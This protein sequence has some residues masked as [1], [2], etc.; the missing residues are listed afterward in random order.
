MLQYL[1]IFHTHFLRVFLMNK[2]VKTQFHLSFTFVLL[3]STILAVT[4]IA[5]NAET[6]LWSDEFN[7]GTD[8]DTDTWTA[9]LGNWGWGNN[10]L[11]N[12]TNDPANLRVENGNLVIA[13]QRNGSGASASFTSARIKSIEKLTVKYGT[14]EARIKVPDLGNGLWPAFWTLGNN[15]SQVGWPFCGELDIME[16]GH[17]SAIDDNVVNSRTGSAAHWDNSGDYASY[18][19]FQDAAIDL[20]DDFHVFRMEWTPESVT[21]YVDGNW[22]WSMDITSTAEFSE[23]HTPHFILF[24]LAVGGTFTGILNPSDISASFSAEYLIDYV[25]IYD[26]GHT[27]LGGSSLDGGTGSPAGSR[28]ID[29][30]DTTIDTTSDLEWLD[31][32]LTQGISAQDVLAG[33]GGYI[34]DGWT[35]ATV[36]EVCTLFEALG[37]DTTNC[38]AGATSVQMDPNNA[39]ILVNLLGS[40]AATGNGAYGMFD[41]ITGFPDNFGLACI[42]DTATTCTGGG[43]SSW[44]TKNGWASGYQTVG[45]FLVRYISE[46]PQDTDGDGVPNTSDQCPDTSV[47]TVVDTYGCVAS[48]MTLIDNGDTTID[49]SSGLEWLDLTLTQGVSAQDLLAGFGGYITDGWAFATVEEVC[50]L[51]AA[52]GDETTN[53]IVGAAGMQMDPSNAKILVNLLGNTLATGRGAY[54]MFDNIVG[55]PDNF[56]LACINDTATSCTG[57]SDSSWL[58]LNEWASGYQTV[59]SFLVRYVTDP[60]IDT[61]G[62]GVPDT[63]DQCPDTSVGVTIDTDGCPLTTSLHIE[64]EDYA[65]YSDSDLGSNGTAGNSGDDVDIESTTDVSGGRNV[66]WTAAGEWLEYQVNLSAGIYSVKS[67]VAS[68]VSTGAYE[69]MLE[70]VVFAS[71]TVA[72]TGGWQVWETHDLGHITIDTSRQYTLRVNVTGN[73]FNLNWFELTQVVEVDTDADGVPDA[74]DQCHGT[75]SGS[76]VDIQG[77]E[78]VAVNNEVSFANERLV[79]GVDSLFPSFTLYT[80]DNDLSAP[81]SSVCNQGCATTWPPVLVEDVEASGVN[82]LSTIE[83]DDGT[84]QATYNGRP[85]YF[86]AGDNAIND[87]RGDGAGGVWSLVTDD[88]LG[89]VSALYDESTVLEPD[90]QFETDVALVTRF[91]DRPRTRHAREDEFQSYDHYIKFY[92]ENRSSNIEIVDYVAKGGDTIE[93]NVRTLFPLSPIEAENRW[94]YQGIY[95]VAQYASNGTMNYQGFDGIYYHYQKTSNNNTRLGRPIQPGDRMEFEI[96]QFSAAGIPRGQANYYGTTFLYIV[97]EGIVPWY[98]EAAGSHFREDSQKIPEEYW[99]GGNTTIHHQYTDEPNDNFLQMATNLG[100]DNGQTFLLGRRV[101]HSSVIDGTHDEDPAN[102]VLTASV[103]LAGTHY[104][105]QRCTACHERN[106]GAPVATNGVSLDRWVFKVGDINGDPDPFLGSVLQSKGSAGEGDVSIAS[107]TEHADGLRS[108]NYQFSE[109]APATFSARIAPR[110]VGLGLMDAIP[111]A[112]ILALEDPN[113][114]NGDGISGRANRVIDPEDATLTRLG[115]FG[116]K[117]AAS[118]V[119]HQVAAALNTDLGVRTSVLPKPD[120]GSAQ[121]NCGESSPLMPEESLNNLILY[122][123]TLGVRPQRV[124]NEGVENQQVLQGRENFRSVGCASCHTETFQTSEFHPL[125]EVRNQTIHPYSDMLLHDMGEGLADNLGEGMASGSEWRTTPLWG[126]GLAACVTGGVT[127]PTGREGGEIC[128]PHHAY[129]HDG[130]A[131][132]IEEAILWHGGEAQASTDAYKA[133]SEENQQLLL[134]FLE[135]L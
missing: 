75:P 38:I 112:A 66:G 19:V 35:F 106:G 108:P 23:F 120:C 101:H 117:A 98:A 36:E 67:R 116:W 103:G 111:E 1:I 8:P 109:G 65:T 121:S 43:N 123:S 125:A 49:T 26:N 133:L 62:D 22:I 126:L 93:M 76:P 41:N 17:V 132:S 58:T 119:R 60:V 104:I 51:I 21:T 74:D 42:N 64:A 34:A 39:E 2:I 128:T 31:L 81:D 5:A 7:N 131:R 97:G 44:L 20:N 46:P 80:F 6:L 70:G 102:G 83:R 113:D 107:W 50:A 40:T 72:S 15:F 124:W 118:S 55:F 105:N 73:D 91:S 95:T 115:R 29:N 4:P 69:L 89:E 14:I 68:Q 134:R 33:H 18:G 16:M 78:I 82:G 110:L 11:Q 30:G 87:T 84:R 135:S 122:V 45:S 12:Y 47:G 88:I 92:F 13:A 129:L 24:N 10:E 100:Y 86:Y 99:L 85:L 32:T 130:R 56:G 71:D 63:S 57:G 90:T 53:C 61:D 48:T 127:N 52:L 79:G 59:G 28:L 25:R 77:C 54:G 94:W 114:A 37:D 3:V 96:S 9:D 27:V